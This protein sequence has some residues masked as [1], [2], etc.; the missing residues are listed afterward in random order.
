MSERASYR[1]RWRVALSA[2]LVGL[3]VVIAI[4]S[5]LAPTLFPVNDQIGANGRRVAAGVIFVGSYLALEREIAS[6]KDDAG[7]DAPAVGSNLIVD[8]KQRGCQRGGDG[9]HDH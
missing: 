1:S 2:L 3:V 9:Y 8:R 7:R 5:A 6:D 4:A